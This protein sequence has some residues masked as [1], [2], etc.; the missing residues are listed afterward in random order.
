METFNYYNLH[1]D[2]KLGLFN[3]LL[4]NRI[5]ENSAINRNYKIPYFNITRDKKILKTLD[6]E[7]GKVFIASINRLLET[8]FLIIVSENIHNSFF[9]IKTED[10]KK[11]PEKEKKLFTVHEIESHE[12]FTEDI[13][14][15]S[16]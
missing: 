7:Y 16:F 5:L 3:V 10:F 9:L 1:K 2:V 6:S 4:E 11:L 14:I 8:N 12:L 15:E 13:F